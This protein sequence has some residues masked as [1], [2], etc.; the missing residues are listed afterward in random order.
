MRTSLILTALLFLG[1]NF[2]FGQIVTDSISAKKVFGG[3]NFYQGTKRL[4]VNELKNAMKLN[5]QA[6]GEMKSAQSANIF[7]TIIGGVGGFMVGW[8]LGTAIGG[9]DPNWVMA[10]I[11]AGLIV[12][13]IPISQKFSKHAK[14]AVDIYNDGL[15]TNTFWE[16]NELKLSMSEDGV[17][18]VLRF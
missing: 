18:L 6:Y 3:Y 5:D 2:S 12:V 9:G 17:G 11:G 16:R 8:P 13:S 1:F 14:R 10:G 15:K 4:S 7:A